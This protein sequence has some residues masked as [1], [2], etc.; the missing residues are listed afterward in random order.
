VRSLSP[1]GRAAGR[2]KKSAALAGCQ[3]VAVE[4]SV[5][6]GYFFFFLAAFFAGFFAMLH[7]VI[8]LNY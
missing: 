6:G 4:M 3:K 8:E 2:T 1:A 7:L 5:N